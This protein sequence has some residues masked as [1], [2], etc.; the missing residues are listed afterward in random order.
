MSTTH[1]AGLALAVVLFLLVWMGMGL[2]R[3]SYRKPLNTSLDAIFVRRGVFTWEL[4]VAARG[5]EVGVTQG[6]SILAVAKVKADK[7]GAGERT[8]I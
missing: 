5:K 4:L 3:R 7:I 8:I 2:G 6:R 1:S